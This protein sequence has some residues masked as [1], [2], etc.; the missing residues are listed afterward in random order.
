MNM[1]NFLDNSEENHVKCFKFFIHLPYVIS[2]IIFISFFIYGI[3]DPCIHQ[4]GEYY[5]KTY[6]IMELS[7]KFTCWFVWIIIGITASVLCFFILRIKY[8][9][10]ILHIHYLQTMLKSKGVYVT[11]ILLDDNEYEEYI[12][13]DIKRNNDMHTYKDTE[14]NNDTHTNKDTERNNDKC[15]YKNMKRKNDMI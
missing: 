13:K 10:R 5:N 4:Q 1:F 9:Y 14:R 15:S 3:V 6:G 11:S 2:I 8:S 12:Y 7:N